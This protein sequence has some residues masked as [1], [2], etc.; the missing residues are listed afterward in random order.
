MNNILK[1]A[2][3]ICKERTKKIPIDIELESSFPI[4]LS[5]NSY[6]ELNH[7]YKLNLVNIKIL[8]YMSWLLILYFESILLSYIFNVDFKIISNDPIIH[9]D[10]IA[11]IYIM[12]WSYYIITSAKYLTLIGFFSGIL[13]NIIYIGLQKLE[14][15]QFSLSYPTSSWSITVKLTIIFGAIILF[16]TYSWSLYICIITRN[17]NIFFSFL[18]II[19]LIVICVVKM[20]SFHLHHQFIGFAA[21][22]LIYSNS[23]LAEIIQS[24]FV[25]LWISG[26]AVYGH[27]FIWNYPE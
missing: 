3:K 4:N 2:S 7:Y 17:K 15:F 16:F 26:V 12:F 6:I 13:F 11:L 1:F 14:I 25:M 24:F 18:M 23:I 22:F 21:C 5:S 19:Y 10:K 8:M 20:N 9:L 27:S